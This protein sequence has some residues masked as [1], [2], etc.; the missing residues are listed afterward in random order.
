MSTRQED[1]MHNNENS[2]E[3]KKTM[4]GPGYTKSKPQETKR[5]AQ[6][7]CTPTTTTTC[8]HKQDES[9]QPSTIVYYLM[10]DTTRHSGNVSSRRAGNRALS[11]ISFRI[12]YNHW[13]VNSTHDGVSHMPA[14]PHI[15]NVVFNQ[16]E[17]VSVEK[18]KKT[19]LSQWQTTKV[20]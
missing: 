9:K 20:E 17:P 10:E 14:I 8:D 11:G 15:S 5:E 6:S 7:Y 1:K 16:K 3:E 12:R 4:P 18:Q 19:R 13:R 2:V